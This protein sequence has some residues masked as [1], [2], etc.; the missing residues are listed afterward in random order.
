MEMLLE[1]EKALKRERTHK[2]YAL[3]EES[4][5]WWEEYKNGSIP[6]RIQVTSYLD[7]CCNAYYHT[8]HELSDSDDMVSF[9]L[10][11]IFYDHLKSLLQQQFDKRAVE[12]PQNWSKRFDPNNLQILNNKGVKQKFRALMNDLYLF[13]IDIDRKGPSGEANHLD[14]DIKKVRE[15]MHEKWDDKFSVEKFALLMVIQRW[16]Y[17]SRQ[18]DTSATSPVKIAVK[19]SS[20]PLSPTKAV[21]VRLSL[22]KETA[23]AWSSVQI[24]IRMQD[25]AHSDAIKFVG[26]SAEN[27]NAHVAN[28]KN[29]TLGERNHSFKILQGDTNVLG[30]LNSLDFIVELFDGN[31]HPII[32]IPNNLPVKLE[33]ASVPTSSELITHND[34]INTWYKNALQ[35]LDDPDSA[36]FLCV[37]TTSDERIGELFLDQESIRKRLSLQ[38]AF[39]EIHVDEL[40]R[41]DF[42]PTYPKDFVV[43]HGLKPEA[44]N[45]G[46]FLREVQQRF[47]N[48]RL[49][50]MI[51]F[52]KVDDVRTREA[53]I[54]DQFDTQSI[55]GEICQLNLY[56]LL[57]ALSPN[58][59][60][61]HEALIVLKDFLVAIQDRS[62]HNSVH[63]DLVKQLNFDGFC[64]LN[65]KGA[66]DVIDANW[67]MI[68]DALISSGR[69]LEA[70]EEEALK[71]AYHALEA[72]KREKLRE[73]GL[74][75]ALADQERLAKEDSVLAE[76]RELDR[77]LAIAASSFDDKFTIEFD[78][79]LIS[80]LSGLCNKQ[81]LKEN[82]FMYRFY[83][84]AHQ[85]YVKKNLIH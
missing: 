45:D 3:I 57:R 21:T 11:Y 53:Q 38:P 41:N 23:T 1:S 37:M 58:L 79:S 32:V 76:V 74:D 15:G 24:K 25:P 85:M 28:I 55:T 62:V 48:R 17:D 65:E 4:T 50:L 43:V 54:R 2:L 63:K 29:W 59:V 27:P 49:I 18:Q 40:T 64:Y 7:K 52:A 36:D 39:K 69:H 34:P 77:T 73:A 20:L 33:N 82:S 46:R 70:Y 68:N 72:K 22:I 51:E 75:T 80:I 44:L 5:N 56:G 78:K 30:G 61:D 12:L 47:Q 71:Q 31:S 35:K 13:L 84:L 8:D 6:S 14:D 26:T 83:S 16:W 9:R 66:W 60:I 81:W 10:S 42:I 67:G 19:T